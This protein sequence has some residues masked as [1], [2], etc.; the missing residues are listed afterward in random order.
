MSEGGS[1]QFRVQT[2]AMVDAG[3]HPRRV[4]CRKCRLR[5]VG[6]VLEDGALRLR[7]E[8]VVDALL[9]ASVD[10]LPPVSLQAG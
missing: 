7:A 8:A 5:R 10:G 2:V 1:P 4:G 3:R 9:T 6:L